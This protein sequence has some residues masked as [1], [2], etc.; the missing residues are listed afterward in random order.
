[1]ARQTQ[2][3]STTRDADFTAERFQEVGD[4]FLE[5]YRRAGKAYLD[6]YERT[7]KAVADLQE[8]TAAASQNEW[9]AQVVPAHADLTREIAKARPRPHASC[10]AR[11]AVPAEDLP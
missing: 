7:A 10:S 4:R 3:K 2:T 9:I 5:K 11:A 8:R 6:T 1:M